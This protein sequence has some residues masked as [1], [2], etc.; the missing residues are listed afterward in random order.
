M[1]LQRANGF[2][3][4][5]PRTKAA[6]EKGRRVNNQLRAYRRKSRG[7]VRETLVIEYLGE[8]GKA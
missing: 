4:N 7:L 2:K 1:S 6:G 3:K 8:K 5:D